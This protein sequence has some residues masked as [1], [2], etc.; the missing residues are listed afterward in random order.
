MGEINRKREVGLGGYDPGHEDGERT[1]AN[2]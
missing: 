1:H 2:A